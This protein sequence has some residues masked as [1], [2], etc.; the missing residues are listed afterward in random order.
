MNCNMDDRE[1]IVPSKTMDTCRYRKNLRVHKPRAVGNH[2]FLGPEYFVL[3]T[4]S[5]CVAE[6]D[7]RLVSQLWG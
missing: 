1:H 7:L 6:A 2:G 4:R 5:H 3:E